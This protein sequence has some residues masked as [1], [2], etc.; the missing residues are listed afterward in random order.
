MIINKLRIIVLI[1]IL[2]ACKP[3]KTFV[4][5][6]E[7]SPL[8]K[9]GE[10]LQLVSDEFKF[11]E[12]PTADEKGNV[13]FTDQPNNRIL[14]WDAITNKITV[15]MEPAGRSNGL[16]FDNTGNLLACADEKFELWKID[17]NKNI[18]VLI[19]NYKDQKL[20]GPNDLWI[21]EKGGVYFTDPY[22]QRPYWNRTVP[23][24]TKQNVY[25]LTP[26]R[27]KIKLVAENLIKPNGII[28]T[29]DGKTIYVGDIGDEKIYTYRIN[30][31]ASLS[32]QTLFTKMK[33][34]GMTID[35]QGNIYLTN[36]KGVAVFNKNAVQILNIPI[37]QNWTSNVTFGGVNRDV[38]FITASTAVYTL[39]MNVKGIR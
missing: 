29:A 1:L 11:T 18:E 22:Y 13:F 9:K 12:G 28:G 15:Y 8:I 36:N 17:V 25:Y 21:D 38:L 34:D 23:E 32:N 10:H 4:T 7:T 2:Q 30:S 39:K 37:D 27:D 14:K 5:T 20:N 6:N 26:D 24:I 19:D 3:Q 16:Y 31:D 33:S 35:N